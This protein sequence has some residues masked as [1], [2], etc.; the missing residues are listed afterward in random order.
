MN[1]LKLNFLAAFALVVGQRILDHLT[2]RSALI[3][4]ID[5]VPCGLG[6]RRF[7]IAFGMARSI[8]T[9]SVWIAA[10]HSWPRRGHA[11]IFPP[12]WSLRNNNSALITFELSGSPSAPH[13]SFQEYAQYPVG[14]SPK[15]LSENLRK[16]API[17]NL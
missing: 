14:S 16:V 17:W 2:G 9:I 6:Y 7:D 1:C 10:D 3:N 5:P 15:R 8:W 13:V 4:R 11:V 12:D